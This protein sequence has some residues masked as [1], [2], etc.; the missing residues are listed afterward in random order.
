MVTVLGRPGRGASQVKKSSRLTWTFQCLRWHT[1]M[2]VTLMLVSEWGEFL[3]CYEKRLE[4]CH[5]NRPLF[6]MTLSI[7]SY[8]IGKYVR[9]RTYQHPLLECG[10]QTFTHMWQQIT[11][12]SH[13]SLSKEFTE[14]HITSTQ[15]VYIIIQS[16]M[17]RASPYRCTHFGVM[18]SSVSS[19]IHST[20]WRMACGSLG[21]G[22]VTSSN[23]G[24]SLWQK[25]V[26]TWTKAWKFREQLSLSFET[27][28]KFINEIIFHILWR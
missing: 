28:I 21:D 23:T 13:L 3:L 20:S 24:S 9:L 22:Y 12:T 2:H 6:P 18:E 25:A 19:S 8:D 11:E 17:S 15:T 14:E 16:Q 26:E 1:I 4:I 5:V 27:K 7:P 10:V